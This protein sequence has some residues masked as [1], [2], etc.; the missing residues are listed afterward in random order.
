MF[1]LLMSQFKVIITEKSEINEKIIDRK[2]KP[3]HLQN[4]LKF[5]EVKLIRAYSG[6]LGTRRR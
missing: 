3:N 4:E 6:C 2:I 5:Y 1:F